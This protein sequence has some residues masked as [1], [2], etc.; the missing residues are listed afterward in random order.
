[1]PSNNY[2]KRGLINFC[3]QITRHRNAKLRPVAELDI[4]NKLLGIGMPSYVVFTELDIAN[5]LLGIGMPSYVVFAELDIANKL[6]GKGK[7]MKQP[8]ALYLLSA[9]QLWEFFSHYG[10]KALLVLFMI[11]TMN[12]TDSQAFA[13]Y[14]VYGTLFKLGG[15]FGGMAA[16]RYLGLKRAV[17]LGGWL[18]AIGHLTMALEGN[19][20]LSLA[21]IVLGSSFYSTNIAALLGQFYSEKDQRREQGFTLFYMVM[22]LGALLSTILCPLLASIY[23]W[24][25]GFGLATFGMIIANML[26]LRFSSVLEGKG[27]DSEKRNITPLVIFSFAGLIGSL[28]IFSNADIFLPY[29]PF[30]TFGLFLFMANQLWIENQGNE[31]NRRRIQLYFIALGGLIIFYALQEQ[32]GS[33]LILF[34]ERMTTGTVMDY[35]LPGTLLMSLNPLIIMV[36][37]GIV[38]YFCAGIG[39]RR[40]PIAFLLTGVCYGTLGLLVNITGG[41]SYSTVALTVIFLSI[42]EL[43][44]G[45]FLYSFAAE[46]SVNGRAGTV[47]GMLPIAFSSASLLGGAISNLVAV[48]GNMDLIELAR[49]YGT[50]YTLIGE[51]A[52]VVAAILYVL[53]KKYAVLM[54]SSSQVY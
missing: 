18:I 10:N 25:A 1:M 39:V 47:M 12:F 51:G 27:E 36:M 54:N 15:I 50:G 42:A 28:V 9:V 44:I 40:L 8:K 3:K 32:I 16:D 7:K 5:K 17:M 13:L 19:F 4:A 41:T 21:F 33:S 31:E 2:A 37:G 35:K 24:E 45:P 30:A 46:I 49:V 38:S 26:L 22:N 11:Q 43:L 53:N 20:S 34:T 29:L 6:I 52:I 48:D 23:G 14:A